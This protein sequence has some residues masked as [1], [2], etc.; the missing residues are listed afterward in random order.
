MAFLFLK[1]WNPNVHPNTLFTSQSLVR[2]LPTVPPERAAPH[3]E[4]YRCMLVTQQYLPGYPPKC[5]LW[6]GWHH[7]WIH[8]PFRKHSDA[9]YLI[10]PD[11]KVIT[12]RVLVDSPAYRIIMHTPTKNRMSRQLISR[13]IILHIITFDILYFYHTLLL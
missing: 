6:T 9:H 12:H 8:T 13:E 11:R 10:S 3:I 2:H 5:F 4:L 1:G 7:W